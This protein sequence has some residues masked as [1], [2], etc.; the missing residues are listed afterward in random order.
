MN[1]VLWIFCICIFF[2]II[3]GKDVK[4][5]SEEFEFAN[6]RASDFEFVLLERLHSSAPIK[7]IHFGYPGYP[8]EEKYVIQFENGTQ[9]HLNLQLNVELIP[10]TFQFRSTVID[11]EII[12]AE[13]EHCYYRGYLDESADSIAAMSTCE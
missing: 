6:S 4:F 2:T 3:I 8:L 11:Q 13:V 7:K 5:T 9:W 10:D 1:K 12:S